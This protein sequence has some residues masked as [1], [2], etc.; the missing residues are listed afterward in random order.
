VEDAIGGHVGDQDV[1]TKFFHE[2]LKSRN[3]LGDPGVNG[4][5]MKT[6][7]TVLCIDY[8]T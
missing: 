2:K 3:Q 5:M 8:T 6:D 1:T 4:Q 7:L